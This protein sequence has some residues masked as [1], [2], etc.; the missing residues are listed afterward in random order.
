MDPIIGTIIL[1]AGNFV[2][3]GWAACNGQLLAIQ[4]NAALFSIL[5][6]T[7]GGNGTTTF[8]LPDLR[9]RVP[10]GA[11]QGPGLSNYAPG[12]A[13]GVEAVTLLQAQIP[14][15][16]HMLQAAPANASA[17]PSVVTAPAGGAQT[18]ITQQAGQ[19]MPHENRQP[20]LALQYIIATLGEYPMLP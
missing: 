19:S 15:H 12:Q 8:A 13:G 11:G 9:G 18:V 10:V 2:P 4:Q 16:A 3:K 7:Y 17:G 14:G 1:F 5:G 6:T 20:F